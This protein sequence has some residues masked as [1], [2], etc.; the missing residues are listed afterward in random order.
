MSALPRVPPPRGRRSRRRRAREIDAV[1]M[2]AGR[3]R[4]GWKIANHCSGASAIAASNVRAISP[5][6]R[7]IRARRTPRR[8]RPRS[9]FQRRAAKRSGPVRRQRGD[10][11]RALRRRQRARRAPPAAVTG[12]P[13]IVTA[14]SVAGEVAVRDE[15][16]D[17]AAAQRVDHLAPRASR[18]ARPRMPRPAARRARRKSKSSAA[19]ISSTGATTGDPVRGDE[20]RRTARSCRGAGVATPRRRAQDRPSASQSST[21]TCRRASRGS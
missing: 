17:L 19:R 15:R 1:L 9:R 18:A 21:V 14:H 2:R 16:G 12:W 6:M 20:V 4:Y 8:A 11:E 3:S 7:S 13:N 5:V 10:D